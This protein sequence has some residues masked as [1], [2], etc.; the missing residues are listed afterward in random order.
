LVS[1]VLRFAVMPISFIRDNGRIVKPRRMPNDRSFGRHVWRAVGRD[2]LSPVPWMPRRPAA[3]QPRGISLPVSRS[4]PPAVRLCYTLRQRNAH[5]K[6]DRSMRGFGSDNSSGVHPDVLH[7][8]GAANVDHA[9][10]YGDDPWTERAVELFRRE[11]GREIE[12]LFVL[13]GTG[14]NVVSLGSLCRSYEAAICTMV[15]HLHM[16][17]CGAPEHTA[18]CKLLLVDAPDGKIVPKHIRSH[19]HFA[20]VEHHAQPRVVSVT[21]SN[22]LGLVYTPDELRAIADIAHENGLY[23]HMDGARLANA[24]VSLGVSLAETTAEA[25]VDVLSFGGTKNGLM[26]GEAVAFFNPELGK[27]A[28]YVRKQTT[29]LASKMRFIA[30]QFE[31]LLTDGLWERNARHANAMAALLAERA[32]A[33]PG[34]RLVRPVEANEVFA[35]MPPAAI[36]ALLERVFFYVWN[37]EAHEVRWVTS[38]DTTEEDIDQFVGHLR[39]TVGTG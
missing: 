36:D 32:A 5:T 35:V 21:Q 13:T 39:E 7:A 28:R 29:Q 17:E 4:L 16:D 38:F 30:A 12:V 25:G 23:V 27:T 3:L 11:F 10:G 24:A 19:L 15:S 9:A 31:A 33:V 1:A 2:G 6:E 8:L 18:G 37:H 26:F 20:G 22:E 34:V 14:A